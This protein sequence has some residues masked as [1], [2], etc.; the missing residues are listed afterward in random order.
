MNKLSLETLINAAEDPEL[1]K[2]KVLAA[3]KEYL[4]FLHRN[5]L[6]PPFAELIEVNSMID[7]IFQ[8]RSKLNQEF[9]KTLLRFDLK[10]RKPIYE[11]KEYSE[12]EL[13]R[14]FNFIDWVIPQIKEALHEGKSIYDFVDEHIKVSEIGIVPIYKR[15]GY[16]IIP[17]NKNR[18]MNVYRFEVSIFEI[19]SEPMRSLKTSLVNSI[20]NR[21]F[22]KK[23]HEDIKLELIK[24]FPDLP[25]PLTYKI[26]TDLD[27]PFNE[28]ILPVAKRKLIQKIA[29]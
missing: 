8:S 22:N 9:P 13:E 4:E 10:E 26:E 21:E 1:S 5:K 11:E 12:V 2:Y 15:E 25:N 23:L 20:D 6:Y 27:F 3:L 17:D 28:T 19:G 7:Q 29:A 18:I 24:Q 14:M 16:F